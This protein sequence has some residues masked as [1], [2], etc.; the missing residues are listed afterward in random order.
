MATDMRFIKEVSTST[1][2]TDL[3]I[4]DCFDNR[5]RNYYFSVIDCA[6]SVGDY[7]HIRIINSSGVDTGA[8]YENASRRH[9]ST[10]GFAN[11]NYT[12]DTYWKNI[13]YISSASQKNAMGLWI[14]EPNDTSSFT[15]MKLQNVYDISNL[16][17]NKGAGY[18]KVSEQ[19]TGLNFLA[20]SGTIDNMTI[21]VFGIF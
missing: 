20:N 14:Y 18:H 10:G 21:K 3:S 16:Y 6:M 5:F 12:T 2:V 8:N 13:S 11:F 17:G 9:A 4:T 1:S 19:I 15:H 7:M